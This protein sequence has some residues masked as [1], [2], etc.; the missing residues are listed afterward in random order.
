[1]EAASSNV[2]MQESELALCGRPLSQEKVY[3]PLSKDLLLPESLE[4]D[5]DLRTSERQ[6]PSAQ[7]IAA[8]K[9]IGR[10]YTL[11]QSIL[12][13][14]SLG[15]SPVIV[16]NLTGYVE[17]LGCAASRP[18]CLFEVTAIFCIKHEQAIGN[19]FKT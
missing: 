18:R 10:Y 5:E 17:E 13:M 14:Q 4:P 11:L 7:T 9:G 19:V 8:Q 16:C 3:I 6:R 15:K 12:T 2:W 1:M